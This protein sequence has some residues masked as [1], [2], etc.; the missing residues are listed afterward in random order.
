MPRN[1]NSRRVMEKLVFRYEGLSERYLE[2]AGVW[3]DH[4]R[5]AI[6]AEDWAERRDELTRDWL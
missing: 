5:F 2:I 4:L 3:E 6:T 1:A